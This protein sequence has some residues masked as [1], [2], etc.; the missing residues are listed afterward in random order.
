MGNNISQCN[1]KSHEMYDFLKTSATLTPFVTSGRLAFPSLGKGYNFLL[2]V[3][4]KKTFTQ[5]SCSVPIDRMGNREEDGVR[6]G[7][8][9]PSTFETALFKDSAIVY[10]EKLDYEDTRSFESFQEVANE[11][12]RL[13]ETDDS[14]M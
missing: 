5:I 13:I 3:T 10:V 2:T 9:S 8:E 1:A 11:I 6:P 14:T 12:C 4:G 7:G